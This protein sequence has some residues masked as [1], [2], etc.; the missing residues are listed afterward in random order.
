MR[1]VTRL[2]V[3]TCLAAAVLAPAA[4]AADRMWVGFHDDPELRYDGPARMRWTW[5]ARTNRRS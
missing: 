3:L 1:F 2:L 5:R 4:A